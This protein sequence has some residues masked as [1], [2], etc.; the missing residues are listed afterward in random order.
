[1][2]T[3][4]DGHKVIIKWDRCLQSGMAY[5][6]LSRSRNS[7][8][9]A[10]TG[11]FNPSQIRCNSESK[12]MCDFLALPERSP[13]ST[14]NNFM[15]TQNLTLC[16]LNIQSL[17]ANLADLLADD[18]VLSADILIFSETYLESGFPVPQIHPKFLLDEHI[19][20]GRGRGL[21][22]YSCDNNTHFQLHQSLIKFSL[23]VLGFSV[24][25]LYRTHQTSVLTFVDNLMNCIT[26]ETALIMG[27]FNFSDPSRI[28]DLLMNLGFRQVVSSPTHQAGN[29]LD[30][31]FVRFLDI[32]FFIH[33][34]YYSHHD[35]L[36][37]TVNN[38]KSSP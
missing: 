7:K 31:C 34:C 30:L 1:M 5:V 26:A 8:D 17:N 25:G 24:I 4:P 13:T 20:D 15:M 6:M 12:L 21:S 19:K 23:P 27:D 36:C 37:T 9:I 33:P 3:F 22:I 2:Q 29:K 14:A 35:C 28:E 18:L 32:S 16:C 10:I 11:Q 38:M